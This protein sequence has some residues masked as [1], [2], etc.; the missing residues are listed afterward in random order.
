MSNSSYEEKENEF[1]FSLTNHIRNYNEDAD[2]S[3]LINNKNG[4]AFPIEEE[5]LN[6]LS[7]NEAILKA[8][9]IYKTE[10]LNTSTINEDIDNL[11]KKTIKS[12]SYLE[13]FKN[14]V[15]EFKEFVDNTLQ[16][17][18][19]SKLKVL[20]EIENI[21][22]SIDTCKVHIKDYVKEIRDSNSESYANSFSNLN[23]INSVITLIKH[24]KHVCPVCLENATTHFTI[25]CGHVYC[26][27]CSSKLRVRC[28]IC[29]DTIYK[30][31]PLY[32][33]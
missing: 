1:N 33:S 20:T 16:K 7:I 18:N 12:I 31:S 15:D 30:V 5:Y 3:K 17:N 26:K 22:I 25:P 6:V 13:N 14:Q 29:R 21:V 32:F 10:V 27:D 4:D 23:A 2:E 28:F 24:N 9:T 11:N 19:D 8:I